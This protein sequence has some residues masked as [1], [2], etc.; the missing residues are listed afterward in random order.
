MEFLTCFGFTT[1]SKTKPFI[2]PTIGVSSIPL[3]GVFTAMSYTITQWISYCNQILVY[4][5][6]SS[7]ITTRQLNFDNLRW[8]PEFIVY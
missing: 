5:L 7:Y 4:G 8:F 1:N 3:D 2:L 6:R